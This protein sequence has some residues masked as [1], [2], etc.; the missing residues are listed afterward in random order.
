MIQL[1]QISF[2]INCGFGI[3]DEIDLFLENLPL[4][5]FFFLNVGA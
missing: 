4:Q 5:L 2:Q 1:S 3:L